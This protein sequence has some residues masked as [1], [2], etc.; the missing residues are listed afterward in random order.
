MY[1]RFIRN[2][3]TIAEPLYN[4]LNKDVEWKWTDKCQKSLD[5]I[6]SE[7]TA[8]NFL[9][10]FRMDLPVKLICDASQVGVGAVLAHEMP[11]GTEKPVAYSSRLLNKAERNYS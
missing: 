5:K 9:T 3:A 6:K 11:D 7:I 8:R 10:H 1:G 4:L 2:L